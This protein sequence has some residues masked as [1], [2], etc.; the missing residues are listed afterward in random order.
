MRMKSRVSISGRATPSWLALLF[1]L[2]CVARPLWAAASGLTEV[3]TIF[4]GSGLD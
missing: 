4:D 3:Q 2:V 1:L